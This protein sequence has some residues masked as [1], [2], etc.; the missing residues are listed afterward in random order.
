MG[1][2][3]YVKG[4]HLRWFIVSEA[5]R[6]KGAGNRLIET[7]VDFCRRKRYSRVY[8]WTFEG[9][10]AARHLYERA[11]FVLVEQHRG[12]QWGSEVTEQRFELRI[13]GPHNETLQPTR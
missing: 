3:P 7:A 1:C 6:G 13:A 4:A 9:L 2:M 5:L 12:K 10:D 8:L 11:G